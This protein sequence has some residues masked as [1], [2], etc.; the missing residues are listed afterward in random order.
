VCC[1]VICKHIIFGLC[2]MWTRPRRVDELPIG[3]STYSGISAKHLC[4]LFRR[5]IGTCQ[6]RS[7]GYF[8]CAI[9]LT[10]PVLLIRCPNATIWS[11]LGEVRYRQL[12]TSAESVLVRCKSANKWGTC[13]RVYYG[14]RF[15][16]SSCSCRT[17]TQ[18]IGGRTD[19]RRPSKFGYAVLR[20]LAS[21]GTVGSKFLNT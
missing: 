19:K 21:T 15:I 14:E 13:S 9:A 16:T 17:D 1:A 2:R 18:S 3:F 7:N 11:T 6:R 5:E 12:A 20:R 8:E 10:A 4:R